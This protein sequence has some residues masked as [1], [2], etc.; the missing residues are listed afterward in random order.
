MS[1]AQRRTDPEGINTI[2]PTISEDTILDV[3]D[4]GQVVVA[5]GTRTDDRHRRGSAV[6]NIPAEDGREVWQALSY[7]PF[8]AQGPL[9]LQHNESFP[10]EIG[11]DNVAA[12]EVSTAKRIGK[13]VVVSPL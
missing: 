4:G 10:P 11:T 8:P 1:L 9:G 13:H 7:D 3:E 2:P 12:Y 5:H 6:S